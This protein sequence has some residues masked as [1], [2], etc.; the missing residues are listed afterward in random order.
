MRGRFSRQ[1]V[2]QVPEKR[3]TIDIHHGLGKM[4]CQRSQPLP[5]PPAKDNRLTDGH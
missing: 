2:Q 3:L 5:T 1:L 4:V